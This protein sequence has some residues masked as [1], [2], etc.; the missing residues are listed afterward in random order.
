MAEKK[1]DFRHIV[2]ISG[3][4]LN[5]NRKINNELLKIKGISFSFAQLLCQV[6]GIGKGSTVGY[7]NDADVSKI[8]EII[9]EPAKFRIPSWLLNRRADPETGNNIHLVGSELIFTNQTDTRNMQKIKSYKGFRHQ[10]RLP[11]RGQR[12]KA[13]FRRNKG[14]VQSVK[15]KAVKQQKKK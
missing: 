9:A 7:L 4:D 12:T 11:L 5:G 3:V 1:E 10:Y 8:E 6:S 15:R 13:N 14:K 2:R